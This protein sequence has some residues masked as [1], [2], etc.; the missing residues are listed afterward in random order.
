MR[1]QTPKV[2]H[3]LCGRPMVLWPVHAA[4]QAGAGKVVV[5]DSP[6]RALEE[7]LP[8]GVE[9]AVQPQS[10]GTRRRGRAGFRGCS[11]PIGLPTRRWWSSAGMCRS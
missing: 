8:A 3:E 9:L 2:L 7:V 6:D 11:A 5:V 1:S 10:D 4:L